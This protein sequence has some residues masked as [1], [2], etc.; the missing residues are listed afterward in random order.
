MATWFNRLTIRSKL[1]V[2]FSITIGLLIV[3]VIITALATQIDTQNNIDSLLKVE[4]YSAELALQTTNLVSI[5]RQ[6]ENAYLLEYERL[7]FQKARETHVSQLE[8]QVKD[9]LYNL[10]ELRRLQIN[11]RNEAREDESSAQ[12]DPRIRDLERIENGITNNKRYFLETVVLL[13]TRGLK[14]TGLIGEFQAKAHEIETIVN[15][16]RL[17]Q[18]IIDIL[19]IRRFEAAYLLYGGANNITS[20]QSAVTTFKNHVLETELTSIEQQ[21]L[22]NLADEY[23]TLLE[24]LATLDAEIEQKTILFQQS[25]YSAQPSL[26]AFYQTELKYKDTAQLAMS[27]RSQIASLIVGSI[28]L[29]AI[30]IG[31]VIAFKLSERISEAVE[32]VAL[33]ARNISKGDVEQSVLITSKDELGDMATAFNR[34]ITYQQTMASVALQLAHGNV[35][36]DIT[37]QSDKDVLGQAF[38][39]MI[40]YQ[41][42]IAEAANRLSQGDLTVEIVPQAENDLLSHAF[43]QMVVNLR[44][45]TTANETQIWL[46]T[47]QA[48]LGKVM[49]G[50]LNLSTLAQNVITQLCH[51]LSAQMG[52]LYLVQG[53]ILQLTG[54]Y[55][56]THRKNLANQFKFGEGIIGQVALEKQPILISNLPDDYVTITSSLGETS[57]KA[58]LA[59]P[60]IYEEQVMGVV[61]LGTLTPFTKTHLNFVAMVME[62]IA[63][64][65]H[66][67][68]ARQRMNEL[69]T[70]TQIQ[71]QE[72][73]TQQEELR[74][75]NEELEAQTESLRVSETRLRQKQAE[76]KITNTELEEKATALEESSV[77]LRE[78]QKAVDRQ[79]QALK[80][81]QAELK[82]QTEELAMASKY[83]S[84]FLA[85][86]SHELRTP[87]NSLLILARML[88]NNE[89]GN[90][91]DEQVESATIIYNG[92]HD[93]LD[94]INEI[95]DLSK[96]EAGKMSFHIEDFLLADLIDMAQTQFGPLT[97]EKGV[98]LK[99]VLEDGLPAYLKTDA[100]RLKQI[101]KNL[102]SNAL[103][104]TQEGFIELAITRPEPTVNLARADLNPAKTVAIRVT[105]TGIGISSEQQKF[106]FE[107]F[108]QADG[109]TSRQYGGT[110]LGLSISRELTM[111]LGGFIDL[112]SQVGKG[113]TFTVYMPE[114][115]PAELLAEATTATKPTIARRLNRSKNLVK[116]TPA[117]TPT[118]STDQSKQTSSKPQSFHSITDDR[119]DLTS[120]DKILLVIEDDLNFAKILY[121][122]AHQKGFKCLIAQDGQIGVDL[123]FQY[124]P[125]AIL[126]DLHLPTLSGWQIL[127]ILKHNPDTRHI[128]VHIISIDD[129][130][131]TAYQKGAMGYLTKPVT[132]E[133]LDQSFQQIEQFIERDIK[134]L[135]LVEDDK[136]LRQSINKLLSGN[137]IKI[138]ET[139]LGQ[140]ALALL[141]QQLFDCV[142]LD[143]TLPD[144][145]GFELL[146]MMN[147]D[148]SIYQCPVIVYT[149]RALTR[150]ENSRLLQYADSVIVKGVKSPERLLD[151]TALF[152]HR[153][154]ANLPDDKQ[155]TIKQLYNQDELLQGKK[156]LV[157]DDDMRNSFAL[158]K[159]LSE[160]GLTVE[161][162]PNG[163]K[164]IDMLATHADIDLILMDVMMPVMDGL[165]A[166][167][168]IR[169]QPKYRDLPILALTAKA[170]KGDR[171]ACLTAGAN[172][173]LAKPLD[174]DRLL[175][176]LRVWLYQ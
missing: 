146:N 72:L 64:V 144:M 86:M 169:E 31:F 171:E 156:I 128:P 104:F 96:V 131:I 3:L 54:S 168:R 44:E 166:I 63:I 132:S 61:E 87:L 154:V 16:Q 99:M 90:L 94:L 149:G 42:V 17:D 38:L 136:T 85:N 123:V 122:M 88:A 130:T 165:E 173:Y 102:L 112:T 142:I 41:Q 91:T 45:V 107:A 160:K 140:E 24:Q 69:L 56:Y 141:R 93:L 138:L 26:E 35:T 151:E 75:T 108:Q 60:F 153:I 59:S 30:I 10:Q 101:I 43:Q 84:E 36:V 79:N 78:K 80:A 161:I 117:P 143:L 47:G 70:E 175:S 89:Q 33:A 58:L 50:Q 97:R 52:T 12:N 129:E 4:V 176:M 109:S 148:N 82:Q 157:A 95:L 127:E 15:A 53:E 120:H 164:A 150:E 2:A 67:A 55:A 124:N 37:P 155:K 126:L 21:Q 57:P 103:K 139:G 121:D 174:T 48:E 135:L 22:I 28:G 105:D 68:Q 18:L 119:D 9:S 163:Q 118:D 6:A 158:S 92:G 8:E 100:Q 111:R 51:Y 7:G 71:A 134:N 115:A 19:I 125:L 73:Q 159:L 162:A 81:A 113:S 66:T 106:V 147:E 20:L 32:V 172:D 29:L 152:L 77:A 74:V 170:M 40:H 1:L 25:I 39:Q 76:L 62:S 98:E 145:T 133:T 23:Q 83:K 46:T 116:P 49:R 34:M 14:N 5:I 27:E 65:F 13:E 167:K 137:D 110:G 114:R 11:H